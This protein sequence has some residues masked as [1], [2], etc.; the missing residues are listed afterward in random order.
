MQPPAERHVI[1][2]Q[3]LTTDEQGRVRLRVS[4]DPGNG[5]R[6]F[7]PLESRGTLT[8]LP[9]AEIGP[10]GVAYASTVVRV[11]PAKFTPPY[12]LTYVDVDGVR[13]LAHSP[14]QDPIRPGTPVQLVLARIGTDQTPGHPGQAPGA[15]TE[16]WSY[17]A[18]AVEEGEA[19]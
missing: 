3:W 13:V 15:A 16:L 11:G 2:E 12:V 6:W 4:E 9:E 18:T 17:T 14:G 8:E 1:G 19:R 10:S 5:S 7:P